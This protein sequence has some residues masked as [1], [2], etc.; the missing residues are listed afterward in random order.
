MVKRTPGYGAAVDVGEAA[1][2]G[3]A[4]QGKGDRRAVEA[5]QILGSY[6][7]RA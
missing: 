5:A 6:I 7:T 4:G 1:M 2:D 3:M